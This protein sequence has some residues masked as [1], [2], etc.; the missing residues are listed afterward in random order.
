MLLTIAKAD[1]LLPLDRRLDRRGRWRGRAA[2]GDSLLCFDGESIEW[3]G[4]TI[5]RAPMFFRV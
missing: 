3:V 1:S 2:A 4:R 5:G